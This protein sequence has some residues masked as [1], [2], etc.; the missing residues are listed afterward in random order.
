[1]LCREQVLYSYSG[2]F[3]TVFQ[4]NLPYIQ[5]LLASCALHCNVD[6]MFDLPD[7]QLSLCL[8]VVALT[9]MSCNGTSIQILFCTKFSLLSEYEMSCIYSAS[10]RFASWGSGIIVDSTACYYQIQQETAL[11]NVKQQEESN[12]VI[13]KNYINNQKTACFC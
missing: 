4:Q 8:L 11:S 10:Q 6:Q 2:C 1:M 3:S 5:F 9:R 13:L 7:L 12:T